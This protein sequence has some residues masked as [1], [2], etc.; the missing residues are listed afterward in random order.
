MRKRNESLNKRLAR[1]EL[2]FLRRYKLFEITHCSI[3]KRLEKQ[4]RRTNTEDDWKQRISM[5]SQ[6]KLRDGA[7]TKWKLKPKK[8]INNNGGIKNRARK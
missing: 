7:I 2:I 3:V 1:E 8:Q 5:Q 6:R 4:C